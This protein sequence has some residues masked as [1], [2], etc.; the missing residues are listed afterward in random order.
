MRG[1]CAYLGGSEAEGGGVCVRPF[2]ILKHQ[3]SVLRQRQVVTCGQVSESER[4]TPADVAPAPTDKV[5][6]V[7]TKENTQE[8]IKQDKS[9]PSQPRSN[10]AD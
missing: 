10:S 2:S 7:I 4:L 8:D 5:T 3:P 9:C 6:T 1:T